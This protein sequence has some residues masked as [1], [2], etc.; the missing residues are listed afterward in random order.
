MPA[1]SDDDP[2]ARPGTAVQPVADD[3]KGLLSHA[4]MIE[5][6][7]AMEGNDPRVQLFNSES[8]HWVDPGCLAGLGDNTQEVKP[9]KARRILP[10]RSRDRSQ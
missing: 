9:L 5:D 8:G 2:L 1:P 6:R 3:P 4:R 7:W 10:H